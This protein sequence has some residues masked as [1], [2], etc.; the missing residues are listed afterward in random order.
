MELSGT[1]PP[2]RVREPIPFDRPPPHLEIREGT[3]VLLDLPSRRVVAENLMVPVSS[4]AGAVSF[5]TGLDG[6]ARGIPP[7]TIVNASL[8][9][10]VA[11]APS[12]AAGPW[13]TDDLTAASLSHE[14][15]GTPR[16]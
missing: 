11:G 14:I 9:G 12:D 15:D 16:P 8:L 10:R 7:N 5:V 2:S 6:S 13:A 1:R 4:I 3:A